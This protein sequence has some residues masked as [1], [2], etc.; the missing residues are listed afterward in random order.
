M[1]PI[2]N[3]DETLD[4]DPRTMGWHLQPNRLQKVNKNNSLA[5]IAG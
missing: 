4:L 2:T 1:K 5:D 3:I